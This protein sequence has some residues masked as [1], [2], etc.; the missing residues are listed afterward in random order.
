MLHGEQVTLRGVTR[1]DLERLWRFNNDLRGELAGGGDPPVPQSLDRLRAELDREAAAG[2]RDGAD[3]AIEV[4]GLMV[5]R[6]GLIGIDATHRTAML[7]IGIGDPAYW[8]Q[9]YGRAAVRLLLDYAFRLRN[10]RRVWLWVHADNERA[11]R[12]YRAAG[13]VEEG[14]LRQHVWSNG[15]YVDGV[16]MGVLRDEWQQA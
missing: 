4:D 13:F 15:R 12:A 10:L 7:G 6:C 5:G 3:F 11:I 14:R 9:E 2:G 16:Q 1:D 8:G